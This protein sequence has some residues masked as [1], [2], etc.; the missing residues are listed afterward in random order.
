MNGE[1]SIPGLGIWLLN[2]WLSNPPGLMPH[3]TVGGNAHGVRQLAA[4]LSFAEISKAV[5]GNMRHYPHPRRQPMTSIL[6]SSNGRVDQALTMSQAKCG[7]SR[8]HCFCIRRIEAFQQIECR[9]LVPLAS[10]CPMNSPRIPAPLFGRG[11]PGFR[12]VQAP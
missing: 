9:L 12:K 8:R 4:A 5:A 11:A 10:L 3:I 1:D 7:F 2:F 6:Q